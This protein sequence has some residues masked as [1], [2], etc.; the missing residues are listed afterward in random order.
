MQVGDR[1]MQAVEAFE[2]GEHDVGIN[3]LNQLAQD[4]I[5]N[6]RLIINQLSEDKASQVSEANKNRDYKMFQELNGQHN[7]YTPG[8]SNPFLNQEEK[9][10]KQSNDPSKIG[11]LGVNAINKVL[12][13]NKNNPSRMIS[14]LQ[15]LKSQ[16]INWAPSMDRD[17]LTFSKYLN[18]IRTTQGDK[19]ANEMINNYA[20][21]RA[22][23]QAKSQMIPAV[24]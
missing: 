13:V 2:A 14:K 4:N 23:N 24:R 11:Q 7:S 10:F 3:L 6:Y 1:V 18:Y 9:D 21:T 19:A 15:G 8:D 22:V 20:L 5:Q 16:N 12:D 17:P